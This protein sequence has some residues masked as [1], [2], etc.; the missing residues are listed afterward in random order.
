MD[1]P[2]ARPLDR[3]ALRFTYF[4]ERDKRLRPDG[5]DQYVRIVEGGDF[6]GTWY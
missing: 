1:E 6:G 3:E 4:A 5:N 2:G